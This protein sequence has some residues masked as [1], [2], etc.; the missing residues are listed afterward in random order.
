[1]IIIF[2]LGLPATETEGSQN[3][4]RRTSMVV[5]DKDGE[6]VRK[7]GGSNKGKYFCLNWQDMVGGERAE[8]VHKKLCSYWPKP[9]LNQHREPN[10]CVEL[11]PT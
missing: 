5:Q 6:D 4:R 2:F 3:T 1:M 10:G 7:E 11:A 9:G 8:C